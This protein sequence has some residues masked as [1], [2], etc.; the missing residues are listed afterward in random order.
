MDARR[1]QGEAGAR[2][3]LMAPF[4]S[5]ASLPYLVLRVP[6][7]R[8][9]ATALE[10]L[11]A[12]PDAY[13]VV[14]VSFAVPTVSNGA[15][16]E[17]TPFVPLYPSTQ[18]FAADVAA[19]QEAFARGKSVGIV[20]SADGASEAYDIQTLARIYA[21]ESSGRFDT[22]VCVLGHLQQGGRPSP[23]D[24]VLAA[25]MA[26]AA[27]ARLL[28]GAG[29]MIGERDGQ[30][31]ATPIDALKADVVNRRPMVVRAGADSVQGIGGLSPHP[32]R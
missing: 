20:L 2:A 31:I 3:T 7:N 19:L 10:A 27:V 5:G 21:E 17:F 22:R 23:A 9:L 28:E 14:N 25:R 6:R 12:V 11:A 29:G 15:T 16:M 26:R 24:R 1:R 18:A 4:V 32:S 8:L 30:I 13:D